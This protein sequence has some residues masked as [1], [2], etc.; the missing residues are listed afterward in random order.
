LEQILRRNG[1]EQDNPLE[2]KF[3]PIRHEAMF[4]IDHEKLPA[5]TVA[6]VAQVGYV[7]GDR[8]LRPAKVGVV[9]QKTGTPGAE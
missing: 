5:G 2:K 8:V 6:H 1:V 4:E 7:I 9:K 3:D